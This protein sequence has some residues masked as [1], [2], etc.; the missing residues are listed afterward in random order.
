[1]EEGVKI[2][3]GRFSLL[4]NYGHTW[5]EKDLQQDADSERG[6]DADT[7]TLEAGFDYRLTDSSFIGMIVSFEKMELDFDG[8]NP[9]VNFTPF[10]NAGSIDSDSLGL[11]GFASFGFGTAGYLDLSAG[12]QSGDSDY[13]RN[14]VFQESNRALPQTNSVVKGS[15]DTEE[16]WASVNV[17]WQIPVD[18]WS[19]GISGGVTYSDTQVDGYSERDLSGTGLAMRFSKVKQES[20]IGTLGLRVQRA[21]STGSGVLVPYARFDY[22]HE[23]NDDASQVRTGYLL[24]TAGSTLSLTG[25]KPDTDFFI[26]A[27]GISAILRNGWTPFVDVSYWAAYEDLDRTRLQVG[28]RKEL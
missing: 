18:S 3:I 2:D 25:D 16:F 4:A 6:F 23:F 13:R 5:E 19:F 22:S 11:T 27:L 26:A 17:G 24:D 7:N 21:V 28:L 12:Y 20:T 9:G 10:S 14:S 1:M 15:T 8:E